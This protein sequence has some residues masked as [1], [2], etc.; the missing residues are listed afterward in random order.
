MSGDQV[1][2]GHGG[3]D[4][5]NFCEWGG[6]NI[7]GTTWAWDSNRPGWGSQ[8]I[9]QMMEAN[10]VTA[11]FHGHDHQMAYENLNGMVYQ[12]CPSGSFTGSFGIYTTGGN[13]GKTI[14]ADST[15]GPGYLRVTVGPSQTTVEFIRYNGSSAATATR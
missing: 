15:E 3:V 7:D 14:W 8:P 12:A 11:F 10:G 5:A 9:R 6:Y 1:N 2:Y 13:S 4:S